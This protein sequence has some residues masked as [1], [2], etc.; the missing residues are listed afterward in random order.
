[1]PDSDRLIG[2]ILQWLVEH[3]SWDALDQFASSH[4]ERIQ[5]SK[6][7]LYLLGARTHKT[8]QDRTGGRAC[9]ARP[10]KL[11]PARPF[12]GL[13][14]AN[15]VES[16]GQFDWAVREYRSG[17]DGKPIETTSAIGSRVLLSNLLQDY[18]QYEAAADGSR[19]AG[20][21]DREEPRRRPGLRDSSERA[22]RTRPFSAG[23][24][25]AAGAAALFAGLSL[26]AGARLQAPA[27][28][29]ARGDQARRDRRRRA[30]RDVSRRAMPT[31]PGWPTR[32]S[33]SR[34]SAGV[35]K[36]RSTTSRTIRLPTT[37]GP[38]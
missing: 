15:L 21:G 33:G 28:G 8:K 6:R 5:K 34:S 2:T 17:I 31:T 24:R 14:A 35:S 19:T 12:E 10:S 23:G 27:R 22:R 20:D 1:M 36:N 7:T 30:D 26:R 29:A 3:E 38:G 13:E 9:R 16:L 18:E 11:A 37:S 32:A 25:G 4:D